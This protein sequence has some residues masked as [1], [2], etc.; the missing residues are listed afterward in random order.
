MYLEVLVIAE[1]LDNILFCN[2]LK[3]D[4]E[5]ESLAIFAGNTQNY[6]SPPPPPHFNI[7]I[8]KPFKIA[9]E[10][11]IAGYKNLTVETVLPTKQTG[12]Q[13]FREKN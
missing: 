12:K 3:I 13:T 2:Y 9:E 8:I 10:E 5:Y 1:H 6:S 7:Y 11:R 4:F